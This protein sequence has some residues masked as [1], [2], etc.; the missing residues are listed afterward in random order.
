[1]E[2]LVDL[3]RNGLKMVED[4]DK[5]RFGTDA[6]FLSGWAEVKKGE[7]VL[8]M[9]TGTGILPLLLSAKTEAGQIVGIEVQQECA[10]LAARN[11]TL[12]GLDDRITVVNGDL[13]DSVNLFGKASFDVV[14]SNPPYM[15]GGHGL[16]NPQNAKAIARHEVL[17][18]FAD[19]AEQAAAVLK[20][21]GR[22]YLV[23]RPFRL[24]EIIT[25]LVEFGLEPKRL[26]MV[27]SYVDKEPNM[28]LLGCVKGGK[29]RIQVEKPLIVWEKPGKYTEEVVNAYGF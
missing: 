15:T 1:M 6:V 7:R 29:P 21:G 19:V 24:P 3:Q 25:T 11:V 23:H 9:G 22:F 2:K 17:C 4:S 16:I 28:M 8:D 10:E 27:H 26:R 13:K 14:V 18:S 5:F 20:P 12:N